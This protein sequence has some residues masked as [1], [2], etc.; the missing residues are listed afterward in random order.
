M[1][2]RAIY[3]A[4]L[5]MNAAYALFTDDLLGGSTDYTAPYENTRFLRTARS[6][7]GLWIEA[8]DDLQPGDEYKLVDRFAE[9]LRLQRWY[10]WAEDVAL[11]PE[12]G[13]GV[14]NEGLLQTKEPAA[15]M[16]CLS[17]L[18]RFED[19]SQEEIRYIVGEIALLGRS[20]LD[21]ASA[22]KKYI[23]QTLPG[24]PFSGLQLM[25]LMYVGLKDIDPTVDT[26]MDL[27]EPYQAALLLH[28]AQQ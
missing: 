24:E 15:I 10:E 21:Y 18:N 25:C 22:E 1:T 13:G 23:L 28:N 20:G 3:N 26:G 27:E 16:Y 11:P 19:M 4:N 9:T 7:F 14:T 12:E 5:S 2:P 17:A 8:R 6:L